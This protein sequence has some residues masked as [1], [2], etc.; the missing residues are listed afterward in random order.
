[1][2]RH[3]DYYLET[4]GSEAH[5]ASTLRLPFGFCNIKN[6]H[7][8]LK[9]LGVE[10]DIGGPNILDTILREVG[11]KI[12]DQLAKRKSDLVLRLGNAVDFLL[13]VDALALPI[14][15]VFG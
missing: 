3:P 13:E 6:E 2:E 5:L 8:V 7:A 10:T 15:R 9:G 11:P 4:R 12:E 14:L 1:M